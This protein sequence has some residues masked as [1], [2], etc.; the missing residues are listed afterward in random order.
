[1][2][3]NKINFPTVFLFFLNTCT[4]LSIQSRIDY[5]CLWSMTVITT[6]FCSQFF[7]R[8]PSPIYSWILI[9]YERYCDAFVY[10]Q[11]QTLLEPL[12]AARYWS[13]CCMF[14]HQIFLLARIYSVT[15]IVKLS[16]IDDCTRD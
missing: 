4:C 16:A 9:N 10:L 1:M 13:S 6:A 8:D 7:H 2:N 14:F 12:G 15:T 5:T 11:L 3:L